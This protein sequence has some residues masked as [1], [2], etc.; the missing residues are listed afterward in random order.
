M[1]RDDEALAKSM[2]MAKH[3]NSLLAAKKTVR[4]RQSPQHSF[5]NIIG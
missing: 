1:A 3:F 4:G 5:Q 2:A